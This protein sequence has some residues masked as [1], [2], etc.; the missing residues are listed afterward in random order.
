MSAH[1]NVLRP[2]PTSPQHL[3][4]LFG[5]FHEP[6]GPLLPRLLELLRGFIARSHASRVS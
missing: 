1:T 2:L 3:V 4:D 5:Q 6:M